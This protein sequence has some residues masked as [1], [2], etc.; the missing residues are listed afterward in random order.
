MP[1]M[2]GEEPT[3]ALGEKVEVRV[4]GRLVL[5]SVRPS[6]RPSVARSRFAQTHQS[7]TVP[8]RYGWHLAEVTR[9]DESEGPGSISY[10]YGVKRLDDGLKLAN[11]RPGNIRSPGAASPSRP[12]SRASSSGGRAGA[13]VGSDDAANRST[14]SVQST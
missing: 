1:P 13:E 3:F 9:L 14:C 4:A 12:S 10:V 11:L 7:F 8:R 6:V 5:R 2:L